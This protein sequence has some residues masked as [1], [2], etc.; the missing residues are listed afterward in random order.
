MYKLEKNKQ[1]DSRNA[2]IDDQQF[3]SASSCAFKKKCEETKLKMKENRSTKLKMSNSLLYAHSIS[4]L[5]HIKFS[6]VWKRRLQFKQSLIF[7]LKIPK[8]EYAVVD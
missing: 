4:Q 3:M 1:I 8:S 6:N 7:V 2:H 5:S